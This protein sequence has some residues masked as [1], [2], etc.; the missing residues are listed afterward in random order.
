MINIT[1]EISYSSPVKLEVLS[2]TGGFIHL[3]LTSSN[4][5]A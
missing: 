1:C 4:I 5:T 2:F 3:E